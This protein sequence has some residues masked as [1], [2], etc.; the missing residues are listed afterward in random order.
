MAFPTDAVTWGVAIDPSGLLDYGLDA[1]SPAT[2]VLQPG[3]GIAQFDATLLPETIA[4]GVILRDDGDR[5]PHLDGSIIVLWFSV[6]EDKRNDPDWLAGVT[7]GLEIYIKTDSDPYREWEF[8]V[9]LTVRQ[10]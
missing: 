2:P 5:A 1:A 9:L 8:T 3:E 6:D 10:K 7:L 4:K